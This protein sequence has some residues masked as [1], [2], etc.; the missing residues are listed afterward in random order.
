MGFLLRLWVTLSPAYPLTPSDNNISEQNHGPSPD[1]TQLTSQIWLC[2]LKNKA[3]GTNSETMK[4]D[5]N[6]SSTVF[7]VSSDMPLCREMKEDA[8]G[9]L[10]C[11]SN[12]STVNAKVKT[13]TLASGK[14]LPSQ[15]LRLSTWAY[16]LCLIH[17][18]E[19]SVFSDISLIFGTPL[20][21][22]HFNSQKLQP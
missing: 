4:S 7:P 18:Q 6:S 2:P 22:V 17:H 19:L 21:S 16:P 10:L 14:A 9:P 15:R 5:P 1:L 3:Y 13:R 12:H 11:T 20:S 8:R